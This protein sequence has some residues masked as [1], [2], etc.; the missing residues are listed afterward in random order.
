MSYP[1][2]RVILLS[3]WSTV[4]QD[5]ACAPGIVVDWQL[6]LLGLLLLLV[7]WEFKL[8]CFVRQWSNSSCLDL[9]VLSIC[10]WL[11][12][13]GSVFSFFF[14]KVTGLSAHT[15]PYTCSALCN[16]HTP[17]STHNVTTDMTRSVAA[18]IY[19][20]LLFHPTSTM[21]IKIPSAQKTVLFNAAESKTWTS[22]LHYG[23]YRIGR[24]GLLQK[25]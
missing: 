22:S 5:V 3:S 20:L 21:T 6:L 9:L 14:T 2:I 1:G 13:C 19:F 10:F 7:P 25:D 4:L 16:N 11:A 18:L 24:S 8:H 15:S 23:G 12:L 17:T